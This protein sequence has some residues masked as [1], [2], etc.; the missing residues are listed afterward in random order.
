MNRAALLASTAVLALVAGG[1]PGGT[2]PAPAGKPADLQMLPMTPTVLYNQNSNFGYGIDSQNFTGGTSAYTDAAADDFVIPAG[3]KWKITEVDVT[4]MYFNGSGPAKSEVVTFYSDRKGYP[5]KPRGTYTLNCVDTAG[6]FACKLPGKGL[7]LYGGTSGKAHW[8][9]VVAN[10]AFFG[11]N[12]GEWGWV[13]NTRIRNNEGVWQNPE[14][15]FGTG[16]TTWGRISA[17]LGLPGDLAFV[18]KGKKS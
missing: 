13:Q 10:C 17:C 3:R 4:G 2:R 12:C 14:N 7:S 15:G 5:D 9:S 16:C 11:G 1:A 18:L 8:V 6:S